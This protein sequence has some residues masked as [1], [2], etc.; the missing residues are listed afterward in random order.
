[1]ETGNR[2][3]S[4]A[5]LGASGVLCLITTVFLLQ[6]LLENYFYNTSYLDEAIAA[7]FFGYFLLDTLLNMQIRTGDLAICCLIV[8]TAAAGVY[9]NI[10]FGIQDNQSAIL[11]DIVSHFKFAV[12]ALGVNAFCRV[13]SVDYR[14]VVRLPA[15]IAKFYIVVMFIFGVLNLFV[16]LGMYGEYRYGLR[17][18]AF[19]FGTPGIVTNTTLFIIMLLLMES[20]LYSG[21][22]N[23]LYLVLSEAVL[24]MVI[25]SRSLIIAAVFLLLYVSLI[26]ERKSSMVVR[27]AVIMVVAGLIGYPQYQ[28][29][30]VNGVRAN[31][32]K[33]PRLL[34]LQGGTQLFKEYFPFGTGFGTF[35]SSTA[36]SHYSSLYYTLG[37]NRI[38]GMK[39]NDPKYLND[40]FWPMIFGQLGFAGTVPFV[41]LFLGVLFRLYN[42]AR[43]SGNP[44]VRLAAFLYVVNA[45][46]SSIQ[47]NY[48]G[49]NSMVM[50]TFIVTMM[51]F[52]VIA[53]GQEAEDSRTVRSASDMREVRDGR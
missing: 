22:R 24:C 40:T 27:T 8:L 25:K 35:G 23:T 28:K 39:P 3:S 7:L 15:L 11:I 20:A 19:I 52:A 42:R 1:M 16:N 51:P 10:R 29:Y 31:V 2:S 43:E 18:Y 46:V 45:M 34:F 50:M 44:Y 4:G 12:M 38:E 41:L 49:N 17:T 48:P 6:T 37:F 33:S 26:V 5:G 30:F 14:S 53:G 21:K 13:N 36:A 9:G 47:S 32:G